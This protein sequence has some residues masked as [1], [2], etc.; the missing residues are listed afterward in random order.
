MKI[1]N[2][3]F[4]EIK[5]AKKERFEELAQKN[6]EKSNAEFDHSR[7]LGEVIPLGQPN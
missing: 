7:K 1:Y 2:D 5:E 6:R 3:N 4:E